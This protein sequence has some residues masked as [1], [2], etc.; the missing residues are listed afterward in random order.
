M[1][2]SPTAKQLFGEKIWVTDPVP[3]A[4]TPAGFFPYNNHYFATPET[5]KKVAEIIEI[6]CKF[7]RGSCKVVPVND[8]TDWQNVP[9]Q[10][11]QTPNGRTLNAGLDAEFFDDFS[12]IDL[13]NQAFTAEVQVPFVYSP[14]PDASTPGLKPTS[15]S[16]LMIG[17]VGAIA[18][19]ADGT[20][21]Q[22]V[23]T[24]KG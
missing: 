23:A 14:V 4:N 18:M 2:T 9:N 16:Q 6:G 19:Q 8:I 5:A 13:V 24:A 22:R 3:G 17:K 15:G 12:S 20:Y 21:W 1:S 7:D 10:M 11:I